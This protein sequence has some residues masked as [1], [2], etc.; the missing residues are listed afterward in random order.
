MIKIYPKHPVDKMGKFTHFMYG[1]K[2]VKETSALGLRFH[3]FYGCR[4]DIVL[5]VFP[6]DPM[7]D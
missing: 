2:W 1:I 7:T 5:D 6:G 4:N 3:G